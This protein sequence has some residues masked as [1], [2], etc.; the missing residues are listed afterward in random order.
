LGIAAG[1]IL[2]GLP[3]LFAELASASAAFIGRKVGVQCRGSRIYGGNGAQYA[4][5]DFE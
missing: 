1:Q 2:T 5:Q 4:Y 3:F